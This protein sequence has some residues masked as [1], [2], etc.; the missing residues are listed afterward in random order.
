MYEPV[1]VDRVESTGDLREQM[2]RALGLESAGPRDLVG[3]VPAVDPAHAEEQLAVGLV[4]FVDGHHVRVVDRG[5][6][7]RLALEALAER[8][9]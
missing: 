8:R 9:I 7:S 2:L 6:Q 4:G 5:E 3:Q 1:R